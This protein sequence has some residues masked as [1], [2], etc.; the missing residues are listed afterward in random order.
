M[1]Y[2]EG[3]NEQAVSRVLLDLAFSLDLTQIVTTPTRIHESGESLLDLVFLSRSAAQSTY[4]CEVLEG[5][6]DHKMVVITHIDTTRTRVKKNKTTT[7]LDF[8]R[9]DDIEAIDHLE[10]G[11]DNFTQYISLNT[12]SVNDA[13]NMFKCIVLKAIELFVPKRTNKITRRNPWI[14]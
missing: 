10:Q 7:V 3:Q 4:Q 9:A 13:W 8:S 6:S 12:T 1:N 2:Q 11:Y 14:T 5:I